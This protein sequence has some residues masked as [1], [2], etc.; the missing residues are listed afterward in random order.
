MTPRRVGRR[1]GGSPGRASRTRPVRTRHRGAHHSLS[2]PGERARARPTPLR[3]L[4]PHAADPACRPTRPHLSEGV[5][6]ARPPAPP[7]SARRPRAGLLR[8]HRPPPPPA[9]PQP[10]S[11]SSRTTP[12]TATGSSRTT[13]PPTAPCTRPAATATGGNGGVLDGAVVDNTASQGALD[14]RPRAQRALRGQR[15]QQHVHGIRGARRPA[16]AAARSSAPAALSRSASPSTATACTS[17]TPAPG[18]HPGLPELGGRL[19]AIPAWHRA[20]GLDPTATPEFTHTPG[21]GRVHPGRPAPR[22]HHEGQDQQ[23]PRLQP[24]PVRR[25]VGPA[26]GPGGGRHR[27]VRRRVRRQ[28]RTSRSPTPGRTPSP[29]TG[30]PDGALTPLG[31]TPTG[32]AATC[33]IVDRRPAASRR[34]RAAPL[35]PG[36]PSTP[37]AG[38]A[39]GDT[40]TGGGHRRRRRSLLTD[41][42]STSRPA[43]PASVD[44]FRGRIWTERS[45]ASERSPCRTPSAARASPPGRPR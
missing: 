35:S 9:R 10:G 23:H 42:S 29:P 20:L 28:R 33:W 43:P 5:P 26:G 45:P 38:P 15:R 12:S 22:G 19:I 32:Q 30:P 7:Q 41:A 14:R 24:R 3:R 39:A 37:P 27:A 13:E 34:T 18:R 8:P 11:C 4:Q 17:S 25:A 16:A 40:A 21:S 6:S 31:V 1:Q 44:A 36:W 2:R